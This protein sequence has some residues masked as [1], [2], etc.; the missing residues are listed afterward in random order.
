[1]LLR[2]KLSVSGYLFSPPFSCH[3]SKEKI[4]GGSVGL[5]DVV[6]V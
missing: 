5:T 3:E 4:L 1:M 6:G 2:G